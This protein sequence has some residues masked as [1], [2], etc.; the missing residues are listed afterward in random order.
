[1]RVELADIALANSVISFD[2]R[3]LELFGHASHTGNRVH[4]ALISS[5]DEKADEVVIWTR[6][7][8]EYSIVLS[9]EDEAKRAEVAKLIAAVRSAA[10]L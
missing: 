7:M 5:I 9:G 1:V 6:G 2:G 8:V 3:V 4:I 10:G